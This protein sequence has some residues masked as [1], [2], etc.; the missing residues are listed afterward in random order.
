MSASPI[1]DARKVEKRW[2]KAQISPRDAR[3]RGS[4]RC[5]RPS[6]ARVDARAVRARGASGFIV[7]SGARARRGGVSW[8]SVV[9]GRR[10]RAID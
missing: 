5:A 3:H 10:R 9:A 4:I 2:K 6:L 1:L 7:T 8:A